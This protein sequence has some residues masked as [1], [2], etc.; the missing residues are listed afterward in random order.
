MKIPIKIGMKIWIKS[1]RVRM[2]QSSTFDLP[3]NVERTHR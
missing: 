1:E 2:V 3:L